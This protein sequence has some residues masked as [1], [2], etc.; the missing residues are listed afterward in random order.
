[1]DDSSVTEMTSEIPSKGRDWLL[2]HAKVIPG[3][4]NIMITPFN[5]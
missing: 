4:Y 3:Q 2:H 1:M 5:E